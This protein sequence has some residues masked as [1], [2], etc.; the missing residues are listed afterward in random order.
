MAKPAA[1]R[2]QPGGAGWMKVRSRT[3]A[4][5]VIG[6]VT[7][8]VAWPVSLLLGRFDGWG[9]LRYAGQTRPV[10]PDQRRELSSALRGLAFQGSGTGHPW[11]CPL[12][13]AWSA[14]LSGREPL[15]FTP[16]EPTVVA[17]VE[18]DTALDGPFGRVRH[19]CRHVRIR[20]D[21]HPSDVDTAYDGPAHTP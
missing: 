3:T 6:G 19:C 8:S 17:E 1:G 9:V 21:L 14:G 13:A 15:A 11:P 2:Y 12:P 18:V 4:E 10:R 20:L 5:Y 7:G 16:V